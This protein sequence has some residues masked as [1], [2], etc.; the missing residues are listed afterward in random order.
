LTFKRQGEHWASVKP[1]D[2]RLVMV[3]S[4]EH[5]LGT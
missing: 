5:I 3:E 1:R 4:W 2:Q